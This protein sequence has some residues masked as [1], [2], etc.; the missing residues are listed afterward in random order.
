MFLRVTICHKP[1][2]VEAVWWIRWQTDRKIMDSWTQHL[3]TTLPKHHRQ[4]WI[5]LAIN[6]SVL[7][8]HSPTTLLD[9]LHNLISQSH[10]EFRDL[11]MGK[12]ICWNSNWASEW[13]NLSDFEHG[14]FVNARWA[15]LRISES[16]DLLGF[17]YIIISRVYR[18]WSENENIQW[19]A[20]LWMK[21]P[22]RCQE[23]G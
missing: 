2:L 1:W 16:A 19:V 6:S 14:I 12:T 20:V 3:I 18:E 5:G 23:N 13:G 8:V 21:M 17:S 15:G 11:D 7:H 10:N 4:A 9:T 22:C